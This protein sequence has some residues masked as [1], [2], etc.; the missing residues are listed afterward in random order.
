LRVFDEFGA[1]GARRLLAFQALIDTAGT[2]LSVGILAVYLVG[3]AHFSSYAAAVLLASV[4]VLGFF[5]TFV[6]APLAQRVGARR[7]VLSGN[8]LRAAAMG[9]IAAVPGHIS[10]PVAL[11]LV[12]LVESGSYSVYRVI[13][14]DAAGPDHR[15][16]AVA[17]RRAL[18]SIGFMASAV[19][20]AIVLSIG[21]RTAFSAGFGFDAFTFVVDALLVKQ[22]PR[23]RAQVGGSGKAASITPSRRAWKDTKYV[24]LAFV[25]GMSSL[26]VPLFEFALPL[27]VTR[28]TAAPRWTYA[29]A[30][31][32]N[33][34]LT[35]LLQVKFSN[36]TGSSRSSLRA[37]I[38]GAA[39]SCGGSSLMALAAGG[40]AALAGALIVAAGC[41][42]TVAELL[43]SPAWWTISYEAAP[44]DRRTEYSVMFDL[45]LPMSLGIGPALFVV[46]MAHGSAGWAAYA[47]LV[48]LSVVT[49]NALVRSMGLSGPVA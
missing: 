31:F 25:S 46:V 43:H 10:I 36:W 30:V 19:L 6:A 3:P 29:A 22:L 14:S 39:I 20:V 33:T 37:L 15:A 26:S 45:G 41:L 40:G 12:S 47:A 16:Q 17:A 1:G 2:G 5:A 24:C 4:G 13:L 49:A 11:A 48:V 18:G 7:Y 32:L 34:G 27:W 42:F 9:T 28:H 23:D 8:V 38:V 21:T 44:P 35:A